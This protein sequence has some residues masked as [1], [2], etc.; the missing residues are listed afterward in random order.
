MLV[1]KEEYFNDDLGMIG[2]YQRS[3]QSRAYE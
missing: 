2:K 3:P 1:Y